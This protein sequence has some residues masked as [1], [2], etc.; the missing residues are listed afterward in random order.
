MILNPAIIALIISSLL[1]TFYAAYASLFGLQ[2]IRHWDIHSGSERQLSLE[3]K[4]CLISTL[5]ANLF[6]LSLFS[7]LLFI[8]TADHLHP[9]FVGA[10]CAAGTLNVNAY[11]YPLLAVKVINFFLCG[12]WLIMN[13]ADGLGADY[14]LIRPKYR[15]M[16]LITVLLSVETLLILLYFGLMRADVITSC[17]GTLFSKGTDTV[18]GDLAALPAWET[19]ILLFTGMVL[20]A[21]SGIGFRKTG[22]GAV[23][24]GWLSA[25]MFFFSLA[26]VIS[27]VSVYY[28]QLP[29]HHCP[30]DILQ[31]E[32][33]FIG[34]PL[35]AA[36]FVGGISGTGV[37]W[38]NRYKYRPSLR[39][40]IP[41]L[42]Q[43]LSLWS[44]A[45]YA[46]F[47][48]ISAYPIIFSDF[49]L[50]GY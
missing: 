4:T 10:M 5:M 31:S 8:Y 11:G 17:C 39:Q 30:F 15:F 38:V 19:R 41:R 33:H 12:L 1:I 44:M 49:R 46:V 6:G 37:G 29:F 21:C 36:L 25:A 27:F 18:A 34:Y 40:A 32:Y 23:L 50:E 45:G 20:L 24:F 42:Q 35:Y 43:R 22:R 13:H 9:L 2:I 3:R 28:Y 47:T 48:V 7:T 26:A 16:T 14:P